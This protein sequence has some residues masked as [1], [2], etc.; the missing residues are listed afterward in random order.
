MQ[1]YASPISYSFLDLI[2]YNA[3]LSMYSNPGPL[4]CVPIERIRETLDVIAVGMCGTVLE[5]CNIS[6]RIVL[7]VHV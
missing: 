7:C 2:T 4:E 1:L 5:L 3:L 6:V